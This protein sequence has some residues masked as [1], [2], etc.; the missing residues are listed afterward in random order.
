MSYRP[1]PLT[2]H[3]CEAHN[4]KLKT[5]HLKLFI[6]RLSPIVLRLTP[7]PLPGAEPARR[8]R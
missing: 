8:L 3:L 5:E 1:L 2:R 7:S 4:L 6:I